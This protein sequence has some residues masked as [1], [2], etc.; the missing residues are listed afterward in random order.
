VPWFKDGTSLVR[1]KADIVLMFLSN[2]CTLRDLN[3]HI[4]IDWE[5]YNSPGIPTC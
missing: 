3:L 5:N 4:N 2:V 1:R